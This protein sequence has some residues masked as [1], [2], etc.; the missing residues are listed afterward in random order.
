MQKIRKKQWVVSEIFKD[1]RTDGPTDGQGWLLRTP[2]VK[3]GVQKYYTCS[4]WTPFLN[5]NVHLKMQSKVW[6]SSKMFLFRS[7]SRMNLIGTEATWVGT[8]TRNLIHWK[9]LGNQR[10]LC[11]SH[12]SLINYIYLYLILH[13]ICHGSY[14]SI[15]DCSDATRLNNIIAS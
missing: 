11:W 10:K 9:I 14:W 12:I 8:T 6:Q 1:G 5:T 15:L 7:N 4:F 13:S 3:P 2:S